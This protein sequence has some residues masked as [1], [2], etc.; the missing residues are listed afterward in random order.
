MNF[1]NY[2]VV[3]ENMEIF[4]A[5]GLGSVPDNHSVNYK[6]FAVKMRPSTFLKLASDGGNDSS[7]D[8]IVDKIKDGGKIGQPFLTVEYNEDFNRWDV[9]DHEG[10]SRSKAVKKVFGDEFMEVHIFLYGGM[11]GRDVTEDMK[12]LPFL[13]QDEGGLAKAMG[14]EYTKEFLLVKY[15]EYLM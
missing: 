13:P 6:G 14:E 1:K 9:L 7:I 2:C 10:R 15:G 3:R 4:S 12:E 11:R 8:Y 5:D